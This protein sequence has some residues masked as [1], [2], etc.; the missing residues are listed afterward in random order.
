MTNFRWAQYLVFLPFWKK[1]VLS[2]FAPMSIGFISC[3]FIFAN[4]L[5]QIEIQQAAITQSQ[6]RI[7]QYRTTLDNM[8][9]IS[10]LKALQNDYHIPF[11]SIS[12]DERLQQVLNKHQFI[13]DS[14]ER[15]NN[16]FY[17]L[18]FTLSYSRFLML[19]EH[20][21]QVGFSL[22]SIN[23]IPINSLILSVQL[24]LIDLNQPISTLLLSEKS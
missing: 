3:T 20:V 4:Y 5:Q 15:D 2:F 12:A 24:H 21:S 14:W 18:R 17:K 13:P 9:S 7:K 8:P 10:S 19:L 22:S 23:V 11:N 1:L 16:T 6:T